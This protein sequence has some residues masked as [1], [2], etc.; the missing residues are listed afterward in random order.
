MR[1]KSRSQRHDLP[2]VNLVPMMDVLMTIL[3]F[4]IIISMSAQINQK[5]VEVKLPS[6]EAGGSNVDQ[7]DPLTVELDRQGKLFI[8]GSAVDQTQMAENIR[9][10]LTEHAKGTVV[11]KADNQLTYQK[12]A[13]VLGTMRDVGGNQVSLAINK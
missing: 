4:F 11:L 8:K 7:P 12:I 10:Y 5:A 9:Q 6:V 2:E 3:V 13:E 1:M